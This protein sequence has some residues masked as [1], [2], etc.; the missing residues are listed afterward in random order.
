MVTCMQNPT[1]CGTLN[2]LKLLPQIH[3]YKIRNSII[4]E[5]N[6]V[7]FKVSLENSRNRH[8]TG[9]KMTSQKSLFST[10]LNAMQ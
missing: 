3:N 7:I 4:L 8:S 9:G 5:V 2:V 10:V 6:L 1:L